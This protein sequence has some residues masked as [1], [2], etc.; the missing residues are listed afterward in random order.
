FSE[1]NEF[2]KPNDK[3]ALNLMNS[4]ATSVM[5]QYPYI[6]FVYSYGDEYSFILKK[7]TKFHQRR[8]SKILSIIGSFF[9]SL[10]VKKWKKFFPQKDMRST[11]PFRVRVISCPSADTLQAYLA[12]RQRERE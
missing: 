8:E 6:V 9:I 11:L 1:I 4:R 5:E 2:E 12:W 3:R 10:Y 7:E